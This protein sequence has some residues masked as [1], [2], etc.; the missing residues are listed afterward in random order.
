MHYWRK[1]YFETLKSTSKAA[2][3]ESASWRDYA[4]FCLELERG[5][6]HEAFRLLERFI[7]RLEREPFSERR[8]FMHWLMTTA[9][10]RK[11]RHMLLPHPLV[12]RIVAHAIGMG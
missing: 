9:E 8:R 3:R 6:R 11:G 4:D 2:L 1:D 10:G 7:V 12:M 5:L